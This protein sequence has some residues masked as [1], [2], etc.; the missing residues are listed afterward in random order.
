MYVLY[1]KAFKIPTIQD[2]KTMKLDYIVLED[3]HF[4][5]AEIFHV[6]RSFPYS[7]F[8]TLQKSG[9]IWSI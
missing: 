2:T 1:L 9:E 5:G 6:Q 3:E 7:F 8:N 4:S